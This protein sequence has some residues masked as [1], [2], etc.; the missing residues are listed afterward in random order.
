MLIKSLFDPS[1]DILRR[2]REKVITYGAAADRREVRLRAET[3]ETIVTDSMEAQFEELLR[4]MQL[5]YPVSNDFPKPDLYHCAQ[6]QSW[7]Q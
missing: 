2:H 5:A 6:C 4:K 1:K 7:I 3:A